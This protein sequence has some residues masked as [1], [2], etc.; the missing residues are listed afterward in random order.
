YTQ[1]ALYVNATKNLKYVRSVPMAWTEIGIPLK[2]EATHIV[3]VFQVTQREE[4]ASR[5]F[6]DLLDHHNWN[7]LKSGKT[8][9]YLRGRS[10]EEYSKPIEF[11]HETPKGFIWGGDGPSQKVM[12]A[13]IGIEANPNHFVTLILEKDPSTG[14]FNIGMPP[15]LKFNTGVVMEKL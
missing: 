7:A 2:K 14:N 13:L 10:L 15:T 11:F 5:A 4:I 12:D 8:A 1:Q 3:V 9:G 6:T